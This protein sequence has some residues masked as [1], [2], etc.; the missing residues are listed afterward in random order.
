MQAYFCEQLILYLRYCKK[1]Y[2]SKKEIL[3]EI[4]R[5]D[6]KYCLQKIDMI[7][8]IS[9]NKCSLNAKKIF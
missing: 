7:I 2:K 8:K 9:K 1:L 3:K 4:K 6:M 5:R